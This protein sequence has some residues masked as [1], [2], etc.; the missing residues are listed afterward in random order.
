LSKRI[1][2]VDDHETVRRTVAHI[3]EAAGYEVRVAKDG[4]DALRLL[5]DGPVDLVITDVKMPG[6]TGVELSAAI[7]ARPGDTPVLMMSGTPSEFPDE[8]RKNE[9]TIEKPFTPDLLK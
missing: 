6:M 9:S 7:A 3:L 5:E 1:L 2:V 8:L 4:A